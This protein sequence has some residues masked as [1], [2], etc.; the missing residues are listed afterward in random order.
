M[1]IREIYAKLKVM[2][3]TV[4]LVKYVYP[5]DIFITS[6]YSFVDQM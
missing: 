1:S 4:E 2:N 5:D 6:H 3:Q